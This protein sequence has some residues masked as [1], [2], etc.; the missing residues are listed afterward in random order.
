MRSL[1]NAAESKIVLQLVSRHDIR[2]LRAPN[3]TCARPQTNAHLFFHHRKKRFIAILFREKLQNELQ[4]EFEQEKYANDVRVQESIPSHASPSSF[5]KCR[6]WP[7]PASRR[8][9]RGMANRGRA[10]PAPTPSS[11]ASLRAQAAPKMLPHKIRKHKLAREG[12]ASFT[13]SFSHSSQMLVL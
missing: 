5:C 9:W 3:C 10:G 13:C 11:T 4:K 8:W 12:T 7:F 6:S 1:Y 2:D